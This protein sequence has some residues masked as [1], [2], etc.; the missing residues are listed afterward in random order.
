MSDMQHHV[1]RS[2]YTIAG[3]AWCRGDKARDLGV[4]I[5]R[6]ADGTVSHVGL[7]H[8]SITAEAVARLISLVA[9]RP[10]DIPK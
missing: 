1:T 2:S 9:A 10:G 8:R 7:T 5:T 6:N 4:T 3:G